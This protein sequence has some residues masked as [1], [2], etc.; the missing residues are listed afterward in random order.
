[1]NFIHQ[2]TVDYYN[3]CFYFI[4]LVWHTLCAKFIV[5]ILVFMLYQLWNKTFIEG[6][7]INIL[8]PCKYISYSLKQTQLITEMFKENFFSQLYHLRSNFRE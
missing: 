2:F 6:M 7:M 1:M 4:L 8:H 3:H 5:N